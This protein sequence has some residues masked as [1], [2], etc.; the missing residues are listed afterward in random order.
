MVNK[1]PEK[2]PTASQALNYEWFKED[3]DALK[4]S[5]DLNSY[6]SKYSRFELK[7]G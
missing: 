4:M 2:R 5:L 7:E 3:S 6:F 1:D